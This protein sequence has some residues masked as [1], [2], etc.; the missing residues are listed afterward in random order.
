MKVI[1]KKRFVRIKFDIYVF[2]IA[3]LIIKLH[4]ALLYNNN[5]AELCTML[6]LKHLVI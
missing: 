3:L 5:S 1:K 4:L 6:I 2:I